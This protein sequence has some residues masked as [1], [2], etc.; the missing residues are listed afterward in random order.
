MIPPLLKWALV[1]IGGAAMVH[2]AM[3]EI[4]R[5]HAELDRVRSASPA[6]AVARG[7]LPTLRRDPATGEWRL[8]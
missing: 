7:D 2:W 3:K 6:E 1:A 8:P 4:R 5:I